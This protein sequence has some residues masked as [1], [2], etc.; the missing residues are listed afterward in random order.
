MGL[1]GRVDQFVDVA[2]WWICRNLTGKG[3]TGP[4]PPQISQLVYLE[5]LELNDNQIQDPVPVEM[6]QLSHLRRLSINNNSLTSLPPEALLTC[7]LTYL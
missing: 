7:N 2:W 1:I 4:I 6:G 5:E 3:L